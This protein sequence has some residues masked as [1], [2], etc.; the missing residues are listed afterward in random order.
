MQPLV[1]VLT[2]TCNRTRFLPRLIAAF[3]AQ[4]YKNTEWI[5]LDDG[6]DNAESYFKGVAARYI[7]SN[8]KQT[9]GQKLNRLKAEAK[10]DIVVIM[11]DDD[12][13]PP[14]RIQTVVDAFAANPT[15]HVAGCSLVYMYL[16]ELNQIYAVGPYHENHALNCTLAWRAEYGRNHEYDDQ[17]TCAVE[18]K[19]L[20][21]FTEPM[22]Q[23]DSEKTILHIIH[24]TNTFQKRSKAIG[25]V[26]KTDRTLEQTIPGPAKHSY[27]YAY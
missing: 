17:E 11:D 12:Y 27:L 22:I 8:Q 13:Y 3:K 24:S 9:M 25:F 21:E 23:L 2:S 5:I 6:M 16:T 18:S 19:F 15:K 20:N 26:C 7:H 14:E 10:G 4:T 1:S